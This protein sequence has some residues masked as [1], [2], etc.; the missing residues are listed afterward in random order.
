MCIRDRGY[1]HLP[2]ES[3]FDDKYFAQLAA[4]NLVTRFK[5]Y[6]P[7]AE[8]VQTRARN[9]ALDCLLLALVAMRLS[10]KNLKLFGALQ[11]PEPAE[12]DAAPEPPPADLPPHAHLSALIKNRHAARYGR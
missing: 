7:L 1:I 5:G 12:A 2:R 4:E 11:Q 3:A 10:G 6:R 9:E 8:W